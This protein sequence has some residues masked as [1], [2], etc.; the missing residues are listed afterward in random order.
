MPKFVIERTVP[1][2]G[3]MDAA[4]LASIA[5]HSNEVLR[6]LGPDIQWVHSYVADDK[7]FCLYRATDE[8]LIREHGRCGGFPVD[9]VYEVRATIDPATADLV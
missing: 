2:A 7:M 4:A 3:Q 9:A 5:G 6:G 8:G 1:G